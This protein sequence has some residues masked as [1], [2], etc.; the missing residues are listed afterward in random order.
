MQ[1]HAHLAEHRATQPGAIERLASRLQIV[2]AVDDLG[3]ASWN[4][5]SPSM[6]NMVETGLALTA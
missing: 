5:D 1:R 3:S 4:A 6:A 2:G